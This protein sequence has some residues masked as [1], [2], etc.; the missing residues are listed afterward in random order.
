M[1][2]AAPPTVD[3]V[4][5]FEAHRG[6]F[7]GND[8]HV[9]ATLELHARGY[10]VVAA[11]T[12]QS[13]A[14]DQATGASRVA[15]EG[16]TL[17]AIAADWAEPGGRRREFVP[18][19]TTG[20][21]TPRE[22]LD[23][24]TASWP[25][26]AR[27]YLA[28]TWTV[29][30]GARVLTLLKEA[31]GLRVSDALVGLTDAAPYLSAMY[32]GPQ[33]AHVGIDLAVLRVDDL[34]PTDAVLRTSLA[35]GS[36][37][38]SL[39]VG[40]GA[41]PES[42]ERGLQFLQREVG[43]GGRWQERNAA[44]AA[45]L[46][47][48]EADPGTTPAARAVA[49]DERAWLDAQSRRLADLGTWLEAVIAGDATRAPWWLRPRE[50]AAPGSSS[51]RALVENWLTEHP[52]AIAGALAIGPGWYEDDV[53]YL[54]VWGAR[55]FLTEG[56]AGFARRDDVV[57]FLDKRTGEVRVDT[58]TANVERIAAMAPVTVDA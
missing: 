18:L 16:R 19:S 26:G 3:D 29:T 51:P 15:F 58:H 43:V 2:V 50:A 11:P 7:T 37:E 57:L 42:T 54:P 8:H 14:V 10:D 56:R 52:P 13:I 38:E 48:V 27:G 36:A 53:S 5:G 40:W 45:E 20:A 55:E 21:A 24:A 34:E 6:R 47:A 44:L 9:V 41:Q 1:T 35:R 31:A 46:A 30:Y 12:A 22:A 17:R 4:L 49:A 39:T 33:A 28:G 32:F 25:V 23:A